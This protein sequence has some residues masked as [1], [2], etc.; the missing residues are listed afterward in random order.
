[1]SG[2]MVDIL[3]TSSFNSHGS[4]LRYTVSA[5]EES[6]VWEGKLY[7]PLCEVFEQRVELWF[8][9]LYVLHCLML[10]LLD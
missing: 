3:S 6:E 2:T 10:S 9:T 4:P 8:K 7:N 5:P 1:M